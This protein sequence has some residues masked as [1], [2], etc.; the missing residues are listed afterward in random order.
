MTNGVTL[1]GQSIMS[2]MVQRKVF[3]YLWESPRQG[4]YANTP[5]SVYRE[6]WCKA[7]TEN[8]NQITMGSIMHWIKEDTPE[9]YY[10]LTLT[11]HP[12]FQPK[13]FASLK[14]TSQQSKIDKL[15]DGYHNYNKKK[16]EEINKQVSEFMALQD[17]R[18]FEIKK[19]YWEKYHTKVMNPIS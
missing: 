11:H 5:E 10:V 3:N 9:R 18:T 4:Q 19:V 15:M 7:N 1:V 2:Q 16:Q 8:S 13:Y 6:F 14:D 17:A 12:K